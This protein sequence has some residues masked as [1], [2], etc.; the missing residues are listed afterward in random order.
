MEEIIIT[1][2]AKGS[3]N[4]EDTIELYA[5]VLPQN[6]TYP[7]ITWSVSNPEIASIDETGVL[8]ALK[9]GTVHC[10]GL[11]IFAYYVP[12][13]EKKSL[14]VTPSAA[15]MRSIVGTPN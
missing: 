13:S 4:K 12:D 6:A 10:S 9:G 7:E 5:E 8:T 15:Q 14:N 11:S 1:A 2:S 3:I